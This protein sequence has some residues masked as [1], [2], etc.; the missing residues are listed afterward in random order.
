M[1][2]T[3]VLIT[4][5]ISYNALA[6]V[7]NPDPTPSPKVIWSGDISPTDPYTPPNW[8]SHM[9]GFIGESSFGSM[10]IQNGGSVDNWNL[11]I[12]AN[13]GAT[14]TVTVTG[15]GSQLLNGDNLYVGNGGSGTLEILNGGAVYDFS[16]YVGYYSGSTGTVTVSGTGSVWSNAEVLYVGNDG[17]GTLVITNNGQ[18]TASNIFVGNGRTG[19]NGSVYF[20]NGGSLDADTFYFSPTDLHGV[21]TATV[22]G[23]VADMDVVFDGVSKTT[24]T[25]DG[26]NIVIDAGEAK[27]R[28]GAGWTG[29]GSL[30]ITNGA[31]VRSS[32]GVLGVNSGSSG[33]ATVTGPSSVW[34]AG[35]LEVADR[36]NGELII[37]N[38]G[39]VLSESGSIGGYESTGTVTV[40]GSG[41]MW[42]NQYDLVIGTGGSGS[43]TITNGA[44]VY[45]DGG[46]MADRGGIGRVHVTGKDSVWDNSGDLVLGEIDKYRDAVAAADGMAVFSRKADPGFGYL[47]ID[48][49]GS[50]IVGGSLGVGNGSSVTLGSGGTL[51][52]ADD[53]I[54][55]SGSLLGFELSDTEG[56][57]KLTVGGTL[58]NEGATLKI[59]STENLETWAEYELIA[60]GTITNVFENIDTNH[61]LSVYELDLKQ[62]Q[63]NVVATVLGVKKQATDTPSVAKASAASVNAAMNSISKNAG[64]ARSVFRSGL[65]SSGD[66]P[67]GPSG[68][69]A[70]LASGQW[71][72]YMRQFNDLGGQDSDNG[73]SGYDWQTSGYMIGMEKLAND[74]LIIGF[75]AG[76]SW[77][78]LDGKRDSGGGASEMT[79]ALLYGNWFNDQ[80]YCEFGVLYARADNDIERIDTALDRYT[81][82]Y[83][84]EMFGGW[85]EAGWMLKKTD[86]TELEPYIRTTYVS[87]NQDGYT[88]S[89]GASPMTVSA[90]GTDNWKVEGGTR[91]ARIWDFEND[92]TFR[93]ELKA[94]VE[95]ELLDDSVTVNTVVAGAGQRASSPEADR[96]ALILGV[97]GEL[98]LTDGLNL[99]IGYEPTFSGNWYNHLIDF[100]LKYE[101]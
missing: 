80:A 93:L 100:T 51:D 50:T 66:A 10:T 36:G 24:N 97:R 43:L 39:S 72:A 92:R 81:G 48:R 42:S 21:G 64:I 88:D 55:S 61:L 86:T 65:S 87:G 17:D 73:L 1:K 46:Y 91:L 62:T 33:S 40:A 9:N 74:Q 44:T 32:G 67:T 60:A 47:T 53:A 18:V 83:D 84:S 99:G 52:V 23:T 28:L 30:L 38:G 7:V 34:E 96:A 27:G 85:V 14:G 5:M 89:G 35:R 77:T 79:L 31:T 78:D 20:G 15:T 41:S 70:Q 94:G 22:R 12:G 69:A 25:V 58:Y 4:L 49:E 76:Q 75:A 13:S 8:A 11:N 82:S 16:G 71:V 2:R 29:V 26:V 90:N 6:V 57:G 68:P 56:T 95:C 37:E 45:S 54:L 98:G 59:T 101:F 19:H 3:F 63:T